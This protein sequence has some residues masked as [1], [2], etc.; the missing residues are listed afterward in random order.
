M[1]WKWLFGDNK[2]K[3][4]A[5]KQ[6]E[7]DI[8]YHEWEIKQRDEAFD[9]KTDQF[10]VDKWNADQV[11]NYKD[12]TAKNDWIYREEMREFDYNNQVEAYNASLDSFERQMDY[13]NLAAELSSADHTRK[14]NEQLMSIGFKH[15]DLLMKHGFAKEGMTKEITAKRETAADKFQDL[16]VEGMKNE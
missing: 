10:V 7:Y 15:E 12:E 11:R 8:K 1:V 2:E 5:N 14:Y 4:N 3:D 13:N 6:H 9:F 16:K